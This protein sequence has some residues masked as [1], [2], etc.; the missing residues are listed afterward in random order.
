MPENTGRRRIFLAGTLL[1]LLIAL[2]AIYR[3]VSSVPENYLRETGIYAWAVLGLCLAW[4]FINRER[5]L[6]EAGPPE[7]R[8]TLS[9]ATLVASG[10]WLMAAIPEPRYVAL[11][12]VS[13]LSGL[14]LAIYGSAG[15]M[16][17]VT[18]GVFAFA[19]AFPQVF[20][21]Y[22]EKQYSLT[23]TRI[24]AGVLT[25]LGYEFVRVEQTISFT[26][27]SGNPISVWIGA[28]SS[29]IASVTIF[30]SLFALMS[31]DYQMSWKKRAALFIFGILGTT[32][33]NILRLVLIVLA[34]YHYG[35]DALQTVHDYAGYFIFPLWFAIFTLV[36]LRV[37]EG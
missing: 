25:L 2:P 3:A 31:M 1:T 8:H 6:S 4:L 19:V 37:A 16:P 27:F 33:Q 5:L 36:Y 34:G 7:L 24:L 15:V 12:V 17:A 13:T 35:I 23:T 10:V 9:G 14:S 20:S 29:G 32:A 22:L 18:T 21:M 26:D 30:L 28:P 11:G